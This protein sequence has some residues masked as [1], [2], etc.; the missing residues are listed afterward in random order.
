MN[1]AV[2]RL[3]VSFGVAERAPVRAAKHSEPVQD[4]QELLFR[5]AQ[6][7]EA[8]LQDRERWSVDARGHVKW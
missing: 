4:R 3:Y 7:H 2:G 6:S 1:V 8:A 5:R